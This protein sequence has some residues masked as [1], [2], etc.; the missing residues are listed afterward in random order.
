MA[1]VISEGRRNS[2]FWGQEMLVRCQIK[3]VR[4]MDVKSVQLEVK[5]GRPVSKLVIAKRVV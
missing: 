5:G 3:F 1:I 2:E 4:S